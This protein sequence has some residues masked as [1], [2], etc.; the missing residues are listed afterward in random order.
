LC[1]IQEMK[2]LASIN[3]LLGQIFLSLLK[4]QISR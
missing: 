1:L 3:A 2:V 4:D